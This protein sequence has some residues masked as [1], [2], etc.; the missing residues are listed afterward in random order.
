MHIIVIVELKNVFLYQIYDYP[1]WSQ[2]FIEEIFPQLFYCVA[3]DDL[4]VLTDHPPPEFLRQ[5][6]QKW[7]PAFRAAK[8]INIDEGL[9][10]DGIPI[11]TNG[12][13]EGIPRW[14][15]SV[16]PDVLQRIQSKSAISEIDV[17]SPR[18]MDENN[19]EFPCVLKVDL[20]YAANGNFL[21]KGAKELSNVLQEIRGNG[22]KGNV[23]LQELIP[24]AKEVVSTTFYLKKTGDVKW[25]GANKGNFT[26]FKWNS[27][28][29]NW[30]EQEDLKNLVYDEFLIPISKYLHNNRFFGVANFEIIK[31]QKGKKVLVDLNPRFPGEL[32]SHLVAP[33][34]ANLGFPC[35][36]F[37]TGVLSNKI[38][39]KKL[40]DKANQLNETQDFGRVLVTSAGNDNGECASAIS[41][42]SKT[43]EDCQ[44]LHQK[45]S[46]NDT[47]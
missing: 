44:I 23:V 2:T 35:C 17:Q 40:I 4:P 3:G 9:K 28:S 11:V 46:A 26:G 12:A 24:D 8:F 18:Y 14:K 10:N 25:I 1:A 5:H 13:F 47:D 41:I 31:T 37:H 27:M 6:W 39:A 7:L 16:D 42:F 32:T 19:L 30:N 15:H 36:T 20:S 33:Y 38:P 21:I 22:W 43:S 34:M 45:I 29:F